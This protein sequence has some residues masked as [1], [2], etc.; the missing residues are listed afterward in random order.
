MVEK[1]REKLDKF[2]KAADDIER[3][4]WRVLAELGY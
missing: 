1:K 2:D 3:G 4:N